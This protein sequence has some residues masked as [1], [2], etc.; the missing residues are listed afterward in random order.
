MTS[1]CLGYKSEDLLPVEKYKNT[2]GHWL[3][4]G[5]NPSI[6]WRGDSSILLTALYFVVLD[7]NDEALQWFWT[8]Q[9]SGYLL[10]REHV[11]KSDGGNYT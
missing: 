2:L 3:T 5:Q 9:H 6:V 10:P 4:M 1:A 8:N 11:V 7:T